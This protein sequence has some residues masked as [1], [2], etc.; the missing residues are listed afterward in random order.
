MKHLDKLPDTKYV[1]VDVETRKVS[2]F[3]KY[4]AIL[5]GLVFAFIPLAELVREF[6]YNRIEYKVSFSGCFVGDEL[7]SFPLQFKELN[8]N[9]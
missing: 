8:S 4:T 9:K 1:D 6:D 2:L 7:N 5:M 3:I